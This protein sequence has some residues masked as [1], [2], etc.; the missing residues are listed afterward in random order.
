MVYLI[1][2]GLSSAFIHVAMRL[3]TGGNRPRYSLLAV[4]YAVCTLSALLFSLGDRGAEAAPGAA[5]TALLLGGITGVL[6]LCS[7]LML[8]YNILKNGL[9]LSGVFSKLGVVVPT[10]L[11]FLLFGEQAGPARIAGIA[12]T[13]AAVALF[14][15]GKESAAR[16]AAG[17]G[18]IG[19][20][21]LLLFANGMADG[22]SK[23]YSA[24][25]DEALSGRYL[26]YVFSTA[27]VLCVLLCAAK[28]ERP[29]KRDVLFGLLLGIPNVLCSRFL[30]LALSHVPAS[31][32]YPLF[33][34]GTV[35][36]TALF[37][38]V[39]FGERLSGRQGIALAMV[40]PA[41]VLLNL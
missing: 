9:T 21:L 25:G 33:S 10:V 36:L 39:C 24:Y 31:A 35:L 19:A 6:F 3:G 2:A 13:A 26:V 12:V 15:G 37:G 16:T 14:A 29:V 30:L 38:R 23:F 17:A 34:C 22:M 11:G 7:F 8:Q 18:G 28:K 4:N 41:V 1:L 32:A 20:L 5:G 27:L 40:I